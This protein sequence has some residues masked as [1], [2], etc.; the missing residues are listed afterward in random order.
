M[1]QANKSKS[2]HLIPSEVK[3][4]KRK[5]TVER[6]EVIA[7]CKG[8]VTYETNTIRVASR[9]SYYAYTNEEQ[10]NT[11]WHELTHAILHD[12]NSHL[13]SNERFVKAFADRLTNAI[14]SAKFTDP[15]A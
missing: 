12:M 15:K 14:T 11:F 3:V 7:G 1:K 6:V 10:Y 4:G 5:Y 8:D 2:A 13:E 9:S